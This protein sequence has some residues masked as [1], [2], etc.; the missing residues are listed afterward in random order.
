MANLD[1]TQVAS[2][3]S[4]WGKGLCYPDYGKVNLW[5]FLILQETRTT[6]TVARSFAPEYSHFF[7]LALPL[8]QVQGDRSHQTRG[9]K[10][11]ASKSNNKSSL[12]ERLAKGLVIL[13]IWHQVP[14]KGG[15][16]G[17]VEAKV[18]G[19]RLGPTFRDVLLGYVE[20]PLIQLLQRHTGVWC[21]LLFCVL[22]SVENVFMVT[23][24]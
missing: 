17:L 6:K 21:P 7:D 19:R 8:V 13:K 10:Q 15:Q 2:V 9:C 5:M 12:A 11:T 4:G 22:F 18:F 24:L 14:R 1:I 16:T 3:A 23:L 20:V